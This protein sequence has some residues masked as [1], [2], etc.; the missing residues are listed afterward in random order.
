[1]AVTKRVRTAWV[2]GGSVFTIA[3]LAFGTVQAVAGLAHEERTERAVID[4]PIRTID[5]TADGTVTVHGTDT[6]RVTVVERI[7]DGLQHPDRSRHVVGSRLSLRGTCGGFPATFCGDSFTVTA[8]RSVRVVVRG[9]GV[10]VNDVHGRVDLS[11][12]GGNISVFDVSGSMR[13]RS[14]GGNIDAGAIAADLVDTESSGGNTTLS[15]HRVAP[16]RRRPLPR[17]QHRHRGAEPCGGLPCG[18]VGAGRIDG[19]AGPHRP[20]QQPGDPR[21]IFRRQRQHPIPLLVPKTGRSLAGCVTYRQSNP[22]KWHD[23]STNA[24]HR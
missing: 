17:R 23:H 7:S 13:L 14:H 20:H 2:I 24:T 5:I 3:T 9:E 18:R 6:D 8:P 21:R 4:A 16:F 15:F 11:S 12:D 10:S 1:M 22:S 19:C